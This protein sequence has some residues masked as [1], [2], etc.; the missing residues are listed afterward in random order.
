[1]GQERPDQT[2]QPTALVHEAYLRPIGQNS[3]DYRDRTHF[4]AAAARIMRNLPV[5]HA[6]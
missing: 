5:D 1:M 6:K 3:M 2:L 4:F